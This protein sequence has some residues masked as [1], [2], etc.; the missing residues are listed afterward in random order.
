[1]KKLIALTIFLSFCLTFI[2]GCSNATTP[3]AV[4]KKIDKNLNNLY[5][6]VS[7]L[8]T[9]DNSYIANPDIYNIENIA[10]TSTI[11]K[12]IATPPK[13]IATKIEIKDTNTQLEIE[14]QSSDSEENINN[15][16]KLVQTNN[17]QNQHL[18]AETNNENLTEDN[19]IKDQTDE[20]SKT[21]IDV[22]FEE[23]ITND[24]KLNDVLIID[25][26]GNGTM[27]DED[28]KIIEDTTEIPQEK[29]DEIFESTINDTN[30]TDDK[31]EKVYVFLF[32]KIRYTPRY[33]NNYNTEIA[34]TTLNNYLYKV[35]ELYTMTAD[36]V[37]ANNVLA[38]EKTELLNCIENLKTINK[39]ML[40]GKIT[41]NNQQLIA[42][43]N[44]VQDIKT[45]IKR[46]KA[47]NGQL[48]NE[49]NNISTTSSNYGL[50]K[51]VDIINSNYLKILNHIDARITYFKSAIATLDQIHYILNEAQLEL[52]YDFNNVQKEP[53]NNTNL[54]PEDSK[55]IDTYKE[56]KNDETNDE[57]TIISKNNSNISEINADIKNVENSTYDNVYVNNH[58]SGANSEHI[59]DYNNEQIN[60]N[61]HNNSTNNFSYLPN[62]TN[63]INTPNDTF[64]NG[65]ITQNNLNNGSNNGV[66]G[67]LSGYSG[68]AG[69]VDYYKQNNINRTDKNINTYGQNSL[70]DMINNG[71]VNNGINTLNLSEKETNSKPVMV[72]KLLD[73]IENIEEEN[74]TL[75]EENNENLSTTNSDFNLNDN[76]NFNENLSTLNENISLVNSNN[77]DC[78]DNNCDDKLN[79]KSKENDCEKCDEDGC[80]K[81]NNTTIENDDISIL[82]S[83]KNLLDESA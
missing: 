69:Y 33:A 46:I 57:N 79:D 5:T 19:L 14:E 18:D 67:T 78:D 61:L 62:N 77:D 23:D 45:T 11:K 58:I 53:E 80:D 68:S 50:S 36:V 51:G 74:E 73:E 10:Q 32:D 15:E 71:T 52:N 26:D 37:E 39:K 63:D 60:N 17:L 29:L 16:K 9:I 27:L 2:Y 3:T 8:D 13:S 64:Q 75:K 38:E 6:A 55:N 28:G 41:P 7:N 83:D 43:N 72:D 34:Q 66:N 42:L 56:I 47:S 76:E 40:D 65:I 70:V 59:N 44:Y 22:I 35:Q 24:S 25:E 81:L 49:I 82:N 48:N 31:K 21:N 30:L 54:I 1:M 12:T 20:I 4:A